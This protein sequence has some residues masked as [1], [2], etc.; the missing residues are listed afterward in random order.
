MRV[1]IAA[2]FAPIKAGIEARAPLLRLTGHGSDTD[3]AT[4]SLSKAVRA[5]CVGLNAR[6]ELEPRLRQL[7]VRWE[8]GSEPLSVEVIGA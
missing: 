6:G 1:L 4:D 2:T 5:W 7:G 8:P 3:S